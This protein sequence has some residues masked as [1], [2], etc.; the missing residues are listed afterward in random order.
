MLTNSQCAVCCLALGGVCVEV[1]DLL[2][3]VLPLSLALGCN[4]LP[5]LQ[6]RGH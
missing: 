3:L 5:C 1:L 4:D 2:F 6:A